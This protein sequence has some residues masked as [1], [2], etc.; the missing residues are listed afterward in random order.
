MY[1]CY[2]QPQLRRKLS[3]I[4]SQIDITDSRQ[5]TNRNHFVTSKVSLSKVVEGI[6]MAIDVP[7]PLRHVLDS[8]H[9]AQ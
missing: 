2:I 1:T 3:Q 5:R 4:V 9:A 8:R 6:R 7:D